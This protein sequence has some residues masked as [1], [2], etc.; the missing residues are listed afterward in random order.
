MRTYAD[1][2]EQAERISESDLTANAEAHI[3]P[4]RTYRSYRLRA[5]G[6]IDR[7][8]CQQPD[9]VGLRHRSFHL[10]NAGTSRMP[11][12]PIAAS[13]NPGE[14][15]YPDPLPSTSRQALHDRTGPGARA[16]SSRS[17]PADDGRSASDETRR[18]RLFRR[19][20]PPLE[21]DLSGRDGPGPDRAADQR[22]K[23]CPASQRVAGP[24]AGCPGRT[25]DLRAACHRRAGEA[26]AG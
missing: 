17:Q 7:H 12:S 15:A 8:R 5:E 20:R 11:W 22:R 3:L 21:R 25:G 13:T 23:P 6:K 4:P 18:Q 16:R 26:G 10:A 9:A 1:W 2:E 19:P 14:G 24:A